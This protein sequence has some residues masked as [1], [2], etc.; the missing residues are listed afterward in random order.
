MASLLAHEDMKY[1]DSFY[2]WAGFISHGFADVL[3]D[4]RLLD[5]IHARLSTFQKEANDDQGGEATLEVAMKALTRDAYHRAEELEQT[6]MR[7]CCEKW[8]SASGRKAAE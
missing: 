3:L 8:R 6:L 5:E 1:K 2:Y 4:D 7:E